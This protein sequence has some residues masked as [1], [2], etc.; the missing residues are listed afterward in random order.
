MLYCFNSLVNPWK[1]STILA[2][3]IQ[4]HI[5][6]NVFNVLANQGFLRDQGILSLDTVQQ[7]YKIIEQQP[8]YATMR[9]TN[10]LVFCYQPGFHELDYQ[11]LITLIRISSRTGRVDGHAVVLHSYNRGENYL[12]LL[13]IDSA[14]STGYTY[15]H[16]SIVTDNGRPELVEDDS[17]DRFCLGSRNGYVMY[18]NW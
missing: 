8:N 10:L 5:V 13:V 16:C 3:D 18:F 14:S 15:V 1:N 4:G 2:G 12:V 9:M 17:R 11:P 7:F 6:K